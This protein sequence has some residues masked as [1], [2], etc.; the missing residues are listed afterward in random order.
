MQRHVDVIVYQ[1][2]FQLSSN[3]KIYIFKY[4]TL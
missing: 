2:L 3:K 4:Q 1:Q